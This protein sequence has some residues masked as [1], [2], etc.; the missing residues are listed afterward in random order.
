MSNKAISEVFGVSEDESAFDHSHD[1]D[2]GEF[3]LLFSTQA[4]RILTASV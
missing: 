4:S 1:A 2:N 3:S